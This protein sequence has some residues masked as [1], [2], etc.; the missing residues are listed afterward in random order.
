MA[1][2]VRYMSL[3]TFGTAPAGILASESC[4]AATC[5]PM[6]PLMSA[7]AGSTLGLNC[8]LRMYSDSV[9]RVSSEVSAGGSAVKPL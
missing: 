2:E 9:E 6:L 1:S 3:R 8:L 7:S 5:E 4:V